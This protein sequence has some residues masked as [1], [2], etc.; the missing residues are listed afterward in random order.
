MQGHRTLLRASRHASLQRSTFL[1]P[2]AIRPFTSTTTHLSAQQAP[3]TPPTATLPPRWLSETKSRLGK[4]I[5][6]GMTPTQTHKAGTLLTDL[7]TNWRTLM[8]GSEG[9]LTHPHRAGIL[10]APIDW[11]SQDTMGHVNNVQY[12]RYC[13]SGRTNWTRQIGVHFDPD[14]KKLWNEML[15]SKSYGLI[16]RSI[17]V[18]YKFPMTWPDRI[19]VFHKLRKM[20]RGTDDCMLLDVMILSEGKQRVAARAEEDVVVYD[21]RAARKSAL[22]GYMLVQFQRQFEEQEEAK[23]VNSGRVEEIL[24]EVRMLE[25]ETWDREGAKEDLGGGT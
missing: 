22:P 5:S 15:T 11:G 12:V 19:S 24:R 3:A 18:D 23:R 10:S 9:Y 13:E 17:R 7:S 16:L 25:R 1:P 2:T 21:Y 20:P 14:N 6:F 4:C 8:A